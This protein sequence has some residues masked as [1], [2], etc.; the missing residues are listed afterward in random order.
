MLCLLEVLISDLLAVLPRR[1]LARP[2]AFVPPGH[3]SRGPSS[4][5]T[6]ASVLLLLVIALGYGAVPTYLAGQASSIE[7]SA[8]RHGVPDRWLSAVLYTEMLGTESQVLERL[9]PGDSAIPVSAR[10]TLLGIHF[11]TLKQAQWQAKAFL[12]LL[13]MDP[14]IGPAGI[15][16]SVGREI[17]TELGIGTGWYVSDGLLERTSMIADLTSPATA[18]EYLAANLQRGQER[19]AVSD[20]G[21]WSASARWHNTGVVYNSAIVRPED[22]IKG[23]LYI[24]RVE[25]NL[26]LVPGRSD[27]ANVA[28]TSTDQTGQQ[29]VNNASPVM[30][31]L[32]PIRRVGR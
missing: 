14:T 15:R 1:P 17:R 16:V 6:A 18:V 20:R 4:I 10:Q 12:A 26:E 29:P 28:P 30:A 21:D 31:W 7:V 8:A 24:E 32:L 22:W 27:L 5:L 13:G 25:S 9:L 11:L 3:I 19:L 2:Y 23:S